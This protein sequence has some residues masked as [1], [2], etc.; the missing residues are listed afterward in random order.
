MQ[1]GKGGGQI[2]NLQLEGFPL[3]FFHDQKKKKK[4]FPLC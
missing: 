2:K 1:Y 3:G 4:G